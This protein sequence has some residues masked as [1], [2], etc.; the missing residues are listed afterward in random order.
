MNNSNNGESLAPSKSFTPQKQKIAIIAGSVMF[1]SA[2][3]Y[4][5]YSNS[6]QQSNELKPSVMSHSL[7]EN[8]EKNEYIDNNPTH[9]T[10]P[11]ESADKAS[12]DFVADFIQKSTKSMFSGYFHGLI[13][14]PLIKDT[15]QYPSV[16]LSGKLT[17]SPLEIELPISSSLLEGF[18][19]TTF[20][21]STLNVINPLNTPLIGKLIFHDDSD[22]MNY[23]VRHFYIAP[24]SQ[25]TLTGQLDG[26][27]Q[28]AGLSTEKSEFAFITQVFNI[29]ERVE[30]GNNIE[31]LGK[32]INPNDIF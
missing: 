15:I 17:H 8:V 13:G 14:D 30:F 10:Q 3:L 29:Y 27:Y 20:G 2:M 22:Q 7:V 21:N 6:E 32:K 1:V 31:M 9:P 5:T 26:Q 19:F 12:D 24:N 11:P 28:V 16:T 25:F 4:F 18:P 23:A